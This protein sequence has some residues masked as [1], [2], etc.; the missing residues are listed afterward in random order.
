M[1]SYS[2]DELGINSKGKIT[3]DGESAYFNKNDIRLLL[4]YLDGLKYD[5]EGIFKLSSIPEN[6]ALKLNYELIIS[7]DGETI[8]MVMRNTSTKV[9]TCLYFDASN[10]HILKLFIKM[11]KYLNCS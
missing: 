2:I 6:A 1:V 11:G 4:P 8:A 5:T 10:I 3:I 7:V 9:E